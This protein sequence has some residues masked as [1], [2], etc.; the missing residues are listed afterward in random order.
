[1]YKVKIGYK[2]IYLLK[3]NKNLE[4]V[5]APLVEAGKSLKYFVPEK[6]K[7]FLVLSNFIFG[8]LVFLFFLGIF[9]NFGAL[10][11]SK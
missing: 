6:K 8:L 9:V 5:L 3:Y 2:N 1:M 11:W 10:F 4:R 7:V